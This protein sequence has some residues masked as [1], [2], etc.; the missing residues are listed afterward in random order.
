MK[1]KMKLELVL[2][3]N[4]PEDNDQDPS[5]MVPR[6]IKNN[7]EGHFPCSKVEVDVIEG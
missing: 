1:H 4:L 2:V 7:L 5:L 3:V 6:L